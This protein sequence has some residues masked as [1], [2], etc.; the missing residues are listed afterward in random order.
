VQHL[1]DGRISALASWS[2]KL[3]GIQQVIVDL[4]EH[5]SAPKEDADDQVDFRLKEVYHPKF[6]EF[7]AACFFI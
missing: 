1:G 7:D 2:A 3:G 4:V 6:I 5:G